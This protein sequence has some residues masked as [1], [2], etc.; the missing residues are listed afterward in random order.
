MTAEP[1]PTRIP[2][3][4]PSTLVAGHP[5]AAFFMFAYLYSWLCWAPAALGYDGVAGQVAIFVGVWGP[6]AA[7]LTVTMMLGRSVRGWIRGMFRWR[8]RRRWYAFALLAPVAV[9]A[10]VSL[11]FVALGEDLDRSLF[12]ERIAVYVPMLVFL[13]LLGGG[14][15]EWGWRGFA[16]PELLERRR[17]VA[18]TLILGALWAVWHLPLLAAQEDLS[19]GLG[20]GELTIVLAA[21]VANIIGL[22]FLY[23]YLHLHARSTLLAALL[24][25]SFNAANGTLVLRAEIEGNAYAAMQYCITVV[26]LLVVAV[27]LWTTRGQLGPRSERSEEPILADRNGGA[28]QPLRVSTPPI[29]TPPISTSDLIAS[30]RRK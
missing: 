7:G 29:S 26:T 14:N 22:A 16:L 28:D 8:V 25:G 17:P 4:A 6:A 11:A 3:T 10:V 19:H 2:D 13:T 5:V 30:Q 15:E 20:G 27:L 1:L 12:G 9:I 18:A 23:T 21:T 24:H